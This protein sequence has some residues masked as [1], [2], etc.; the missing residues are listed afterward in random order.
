[1]G[2][3]RRVRYTR[4]LEV[5]CL[6]LTLGPHGGCSGGAAPAIYA[7]AGPALETLLAPGRNSATSVPDTLLHKHIYKHNRRRQQTVHSTLSSWPHSCTSDY[8]NDAVITSARGGPAA[9]CQLVIIQQ[10][11]QAHSPRKHQSVGPARW[12]ITG[13]LNPN[14]YN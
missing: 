7:W 1:M 5:G 9:A 6:P 4:G 11:L 2:A 13:T 12:G 14:P 10:Y 3:A 8:V